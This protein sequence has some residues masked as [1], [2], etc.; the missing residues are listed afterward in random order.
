MKD[1]SGDDHGGQLAGKKRDG[2]QGETDDLG[3]ETH[4]V[5]SAPSTEAPAESSTWV[6]ATVVRRS[7]IVECRLAFPIDAAASAP[8]DFPN[9]ALSD[10]E[11]WNRAR[12][13]LD[14]DKDAKDRRAICFTLAWL[15]SLLVA[16]VVCL[17]K[18]GPS[19]LHPHSSAPDLFGAWFLVVGTLIGLLQFPNADASKF[20]DED[21]AVL[22]LVWLCTGGLLVAF[23]ALALNQTA[24][25]IFIGVFVLGLLGLAWVARGT[26]GRTKRRR[27]YR[28]IEEEKVR[29]LADRARLEPPATKPALKLLL[30]SRRQ[31][32][33]NT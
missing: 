16:L 17:L 4:S 33:T 5:E 28:H 19:V 9:E 8:A 31:A 24:T 32:R 22:S 7:A 6:S 29:L 18:L 20:Y 25:L 26:A 30:G 15:V 11:L 13:R 3:N 27:Y 14:A 10:I 23:R 21:L 1:Q 12:E 2:N